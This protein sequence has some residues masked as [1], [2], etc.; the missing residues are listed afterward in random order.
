MDE[1]AIQ[2]PQFELCN[3]TYQEFRQDIFKLIKNIENGSFRISTF[4]SNLRKFSQDEY[5]RPLVWVKLKEAIESVHSICHSKIKSS[6]KSFVKNIPEELPKIYTEPYVLEQILMN[7]LVN[8]AQAAD[9]QN[10]WIKL[11][12]NVENGEQEQ[13]IIEVSDNG[14]GID[15]ETRRKIFDPFYTTKSQT[16]GTGLGLYVCH[17]LVERLKGHIEV[18]SEPGR[19]SAFKLVLPVENQY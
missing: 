17:A 6:V 16:E 5:E 9:K 11:N 10:S 19:G 12:V 3:L 18:E 14:C 4:V 2:H 1:Y 7:L 8:A 13:I 15:K